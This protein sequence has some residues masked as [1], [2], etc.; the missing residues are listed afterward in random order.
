MLFRMLNVLY[1]HINIFCSTGAV[2]NMAVFW[3][4][5]ILCLPCMLHKLDDDVIVIIII[6][7]IIIMLHFLSMY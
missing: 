5:L 3:S 6:I 2:S 1:V 7:I 4:S